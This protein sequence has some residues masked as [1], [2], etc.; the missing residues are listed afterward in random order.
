MTGEFNV[1]IVNAPL[2][3]GT[4]DCDATLRPTSVT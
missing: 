3:P 4:P 1:V 2:A